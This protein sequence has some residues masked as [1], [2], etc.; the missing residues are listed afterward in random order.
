MKSSFMGRGN[1]YIQL[2][3]V[4]YCKL[5]TIGK[6]LPSFQH[7]V[8]GLNS[9]PQ[10]WEASVLPLY[11]HG[12]TFIC[13]VYLVVQLIK[14]MQLIIFYQASCNISASYCVKYGGKA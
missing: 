1:Q 11:H 10:R 13:F 4:L 3:K 12:P 8:L 6:K 5:P 7:R 9:R 14:Y 2:I